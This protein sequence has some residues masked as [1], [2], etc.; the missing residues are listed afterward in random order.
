MRIL[1]WLI[2][3]SISIFA[4]TDYEK[5]I[6]KIKDDIKLLKTKDSINSLK[7][8]EIE[9]ISLHNRND[10]NTNS[11]ILEESIIKNGISKLRDQLTTNNFDTEVNTKEVK[12]LKDEIAYLKQEIANMQNLLKQQKDKKYFTLLVNIESLSIKAAPNPNGRVLKNISRNTKVKI[13]ECNN[14]WCKLYK[15]E[16]YIA[17]YLLRKPN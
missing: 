10:I 4:N 9:K 16:G 17:R 14:G 2:I 11:T 1:F 3:I 5:N 13:R 15:Q 6:L 7:I 8:R 12:K